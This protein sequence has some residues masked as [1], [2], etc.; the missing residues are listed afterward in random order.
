M[1]RNFKK[2]ASLEIHN[3]NNF[4]EVVSL[5]QHHFLPTRLMDWTLSPFVALHFA[6]ED[7]SKYDRDGAIWCV[8]FI[9]CREF[10]PVK[11]KQALI[12]DNA[13]GFSVD[14]L[15]RHVKDYSELSLLEEELDKKPFLLF[16]E[17][18]SIDARIVNQYAWFSVLSNPTTTVSEWI[19]SHPDIV[20]KMII[21][22]KKKME[23]RDKLD[24]INMSERYIYPG[25][26]GLCQWLARHYTPTKNI[27]P[28]LTEEEINEING[29]GR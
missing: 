1:I 10:L 16:F 8:D 9:K 19:E 3:P 23:F 26:D 18:P 17:P 6:T 15:N 21:P 20:Y 12:D 27:Y 28:N 2:Y 13:N 4:W 7:Y 14:L 25:L 22:A 11:L 29:G 5:G 24:Q